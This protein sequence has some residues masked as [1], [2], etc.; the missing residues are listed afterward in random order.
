MKTEVGRNWYQLIHFEKLSCRQVSFS[1]PKWIPLREEHICIQRLKYILTPCLQVGLVMFLS[2]QII[3]WTFCYTT[4]QTRNDLYIPEKA[5]ASSPVFSW[6]INV[7]MEIWISVVKYVLTGRQERP[8]PTAFQNNQWEW[9][10]LPPPLPLVSWQLQAV[11][12]VLSRTFL[13]I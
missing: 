4:L 5:L 10:C 12:R 11:F 7:W 2:V 8:V 1:S 6:K 9:T 13:H 3:L